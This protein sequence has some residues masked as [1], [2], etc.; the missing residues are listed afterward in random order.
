[1]LEIHVHAR[2]GRSMRW[3]TG[4]LVT[5]LIFA[6]AAVGLWLHPEFLAYAVAAGLMTIALLA[7]S[8]ALFARGR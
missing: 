2:E 7:I 8:S 5:G 6:A 1:M 4:V 3:R